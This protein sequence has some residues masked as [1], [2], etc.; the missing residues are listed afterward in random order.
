[1]NEFFFGSYTQNYTPSPSYLSVILSFSPVPSLPFPLRF[2][3]G[4]FDVRRGFALVSKVV[5]SLSS[6]Q[7]FSLYSFAYNPLSWSLLLFILGDVYH[8]LSKGIFI[9]D[10]IGRF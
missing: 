10:V 4:S 2:L 1:M 6:F 8:S 5:F 9:A 3:P 7:L